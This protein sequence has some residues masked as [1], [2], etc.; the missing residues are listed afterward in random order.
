MPHP[1]LLSIPNVY[2][3]KNISERVGTLSV[4]DSRAIFWN[5]RNLKATHGRD[6]KV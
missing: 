5:T 6:P 3:N 2:N 4:R 1:S